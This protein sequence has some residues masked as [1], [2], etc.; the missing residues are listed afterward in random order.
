MP[1]FKSFELFAVH[2]QGG[3]LN[4]I[5]GVIYRPGS[6]DENSTFFDEFVDLIER[7]AIY[8]AP[9]IIVGDVSI[10]LHVLSASSASNFIDILAGAGLVRH[11]SGTTQRAGH[12]LDVIIIPCALDVSV[13][14]E[15]PIIS[16]HSLIVAEITS[17]AAYHSLA[18]H[19]TKRQS[20]NFDVYGVYERSRGI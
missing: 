6:S 5:V 10:H 8:A 17:R 3:S 13:T 9:L 16:D 7:V 14:V 19:V 1:S 15:P 11:V 4:L 2:I 12:T 18:A 20:A